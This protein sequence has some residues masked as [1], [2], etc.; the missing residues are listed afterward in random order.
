MIMT[1]FYIKED[2]VSCTEVSVMTSSEGLS[3]QYGLNV[4]SHGEATSHL[5]NPE[6]MLATIQTLLSLARDRLSIPVVLS[7]LS[8][9]TVNNKLATV[10]GYKSDRKRYIVEIT[11]ESSSKY[12][13]R[14]E[15]VNFDLSNRINCLIQRMGV[16]SNRSV[17]Y[18]LIKKCTRDQIEFKKYRIGN[19][20]PVTKMTTLFNQAMQRQQIPLSAGIRE[21]KKDQG[22][23]LS[24]RKNENSRTVYAAI[25][26]AVNTMG[27]S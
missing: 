2:A 6:T 12:L 22:K 8:D 3:R 10:I 20:A 15:I 17:Q 13:I 26:D 23:K 5:R 16:F 18:D 1:V 24:L 14:P 21:S 25:L 11:S 19:E 27:L 4:T 7:G 9:A